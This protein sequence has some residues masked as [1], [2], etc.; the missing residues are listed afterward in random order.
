MQGFIQI[1]PLKLKPGIYFHFHLFEKNES[2]S[3]TPVCAATVTFAHSLRG[4]SFCKR[5]ITVTAIAI[6]WCFHVTTISSV[7]EIQRL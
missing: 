2:K 7:A 1:N 5:E 4:H 3:S 6:L